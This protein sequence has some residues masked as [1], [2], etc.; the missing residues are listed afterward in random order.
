MG[1][2]RRRHRDLTRPPIAVSDRSRFAYVLPIIPQLLPIM[3]YKLL[4]RYSISGRVHG[5]RRHVP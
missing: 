1:H 2:P 4:G 5:S 3:L